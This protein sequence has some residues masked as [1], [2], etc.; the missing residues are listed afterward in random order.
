MYLVSLVDSFVEM[1]NTHTFLVG[2][3]EEDRVQLRQRD[4]YHKGS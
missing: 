3:G 2:R 4:P 1:T